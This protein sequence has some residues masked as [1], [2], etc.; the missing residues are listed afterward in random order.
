MNLMLGLDRA[1]G[2]SMLIDVGTNAEVVLGNRKQLWV[3]SC[4][5]GPA[6]EGAQI[7]CGM[8]AVSGAIHRA[9][10]DE[11]SQ[12]IDYEVLGNGSSNRPMGICGSGM[13]DLLDGRCL[14]TIAGC[15]DVVNGEGE[16]DNTANPPVISDTEIR[17][18][19]MM[20]GAL[21]PD[22]DLDGD[23]ENDVISVGLRI[24]SAVPVT[25]VVP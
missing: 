25:V 21:E 17:C 12:R 4:A 14:N 11:K 23:G 8:R 6:L 5:T 18:N 10:P 19:M 22:V 16:C 24:E 3:T 13:I 7:S 15:E 9:W 1:A 20:T 2:T